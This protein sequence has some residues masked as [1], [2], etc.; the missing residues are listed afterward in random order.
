M[1]GSPFWT[2][3][4]LAVVPPMSKERKVGPWPMARPTRALAC[5]PPA[6]PDSRKRTGR[7]T[8]VSGAVE[9]TGGLD[10]VETP[11]KAAF[12]KHPLEP[13]HV[14]G[15]EGLHVSIR[16]G[17]RGPFVLVDLGVDVARDGHREVRELGADEI[18]HGPLVDRVLVG[19]EEADRERLHPVLDQLANFAANRVEVDRLEHDA[20]AA[21]PFGD[22][23]P[24]A[25]SGER[26]R[27][28]QEEVVDVVTLLRPHLEDVAKAAGGEQAEAG[29]VP[30]DDGVGDEGRPVHDV[31][32]VHEIDRR[33]AQQIG[34]A[35]E[36][37]DRGVFR[38]REALVQVQGPRRAVDQDEVG[39]RP[40][41]VESDS[42]GR[43]LV[44][45]GHGTWNSSDSRCDGSRP[46]ASG[47]APSG[48]RSN[49]IP[50]RQ[51]P[52]RPAFPPS[53]LRLS[54]YRSPARRGRKRGMSGT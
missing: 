30:L 21:H 45:G 46:R 3:D 34:H 41:D 50:Q 27:E 29:P 9:T 18:P 2:R 17:G 14:R 32:D 24:V 20:V 51:P 25:A 26:R 22:L 39:E 15:H 52:S 1:S 38:G 40:P 28:G 49:S 47:Q 4:A 16:G 36:R 44:S 31:A 48:R 33:C 23:A 42:P 7:R 12:A 6:G 37:P 13:P 19:V 10:E 11:A 35:L 54:G 53:P 8:A 43:L 5:A